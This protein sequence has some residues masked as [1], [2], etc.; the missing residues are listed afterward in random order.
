MAKMGLS[1]AWMLVAAT[2]FTLLLAAAGYISDEDAQATT[3]PLYGKIIVIDPDH[4]GTDA[5][6]VS[7]VPGMVSIMC[8]GRK[9]RTWR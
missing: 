1:R 7:T 2:L 3:S 4:G 6:A 5:G 9:T 8:S